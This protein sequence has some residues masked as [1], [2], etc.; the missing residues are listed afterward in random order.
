MRL[1]LLC[2]LCFYSLTAFADFQLICPGDI[3]INCN[4]DYSNLDRF[5]KA[6]VNHNGAII[7]IKDCKV[8]YDLNDCGY[9]TITRVWGVEDPDWNWITCK[10]IITLSNADA[11]GEKDITWPRDLTIE[12]CDPEQELKNLFKPYDRPY[13]K[14]NKCAKPMLN[15]S[16]SRFNVSEGC[17]K[18]IRTWRIL[19]WCVYDPYKNPGA[20]IFSHVQVIKL[21]T[22]DTAAKLLCIKDTTVY[23]TQD[24]QG[25]QLKLDLAKVYSPCNAPFVIKNT[26]AYADT[27]TA[28]ASG[29]YP[30]GDYKFYY[31]GEYGCGKEL[32]CEINV[33]VIRKI[34]P[35]PY[36]LT[37][38]IVDLMPVDSDQDGIPED[39]MI[40][41]WAK[42]L[43]KG[44]FHKCPGEKL[45]FSFSSDV[46]NKSRI[47]TCADL[48]ENEV[49]MWLTDS[50]GNQDYCKTKVIIQNNIGIPG[51]KRKDSLQEKKFEMYLNLKYWFNNSSIS[52]AELFCRDLSNN[53]LTKGLW[54]NGTYIFKDLS[55]NSSHQIELQLSNPYSSD[56]NDFIWLNELMNGRQ[57][58][59]NPYQLL[60]ADINNDGLV[61][62]ADLYLIK[63]KLNTKSRKN[64]AFR[65]LPMDKTWT[66]EMILREFKNISWVVP[67]QSQNTTVHKEI[68]IVPIGYFGLT[69][70]PKKI[71]GFRT[72]DINTKTL[73]VNYD[74]Q[75]KVLRIE[76]NPENSNNININI[77]I[78]SIT[79]IPIW[80][81]S[82]PATVSMEI[83]LGDI[84][85]NSGVY[86]IKVNES[87]LKIMV[88]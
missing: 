68:A 54:T 50:Y 2:F 75:A 32:K 63:T 51:C 34:P 25:V 4:S 72:D 82:Y 22:I 74:V 14:S 9:G 8:T 26:S 21:I 31:I 43:D 78:Y 5:G 47:F 23:A 84:I 16:D 41:V 83:E 13:W 24:C 40:E 35:T 12:S 45:N 29:F 61:D 55:A 3:T 49:E 57:T 28:D 62:E 69:P 76:Q 6:Y 10:Q 44:S 17:I 79:G 38:V 33:H 56:L 86:L 18:L 87:I 64:N 60:A 58:S 36:C 66:N 15:Y 52:N 85:K 20:G 71:I 73:N 39:G 11:F 46:L 19:D 48:G 77:N 7:W 42:D 70:K 27:N 81:T 67:P 37:G 65:C 88:D 80:N 30:L 1:L 59:F 53:Q